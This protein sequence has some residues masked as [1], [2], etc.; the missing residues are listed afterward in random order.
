MLG[1][2]DQAFRSLEDIAGIRHV[3]SAADF[4]DSAVDF[5]EVGD[6]G[7][8]FPSLGI[9]VVSADDSQ[10]QSLQSVSDKGDNILSIEPERY[11]YPLAHHSFDQYL[12][13]YRESVNHL[14]DAFVGEDAEEGRMDGLVSYQDTRQFTWGLQ[15]TQ[16]DTS[17]YT[18]KGIRVAVLDTGFDLRHIDFRNRKIVSKSFVPGE[19]AQDTQ[20]HGTHCTGTACGPKSPASRVRRYGCACDAD[21]FIGK[22][23]DS[24]GKGT[25]TAILNGLEWAIDNKCHIVSMSLGRL[26]DEESTAYENAGRRALDANSLVIAAAGNNANRTVGRFG[27]VEQPANSLSIMA[28]GAVDNQLRIA[29]FSARSSARTGIGGKVDLVAPGVNV[30]SSIP[31]DRHASYSGTSMATPH[32]AGIAALW[33]QATGRLGMALWTTLIQNTRPISGDT[34]DIGSG[35]VQAPQ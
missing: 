12:R 17:R 9:A 25:D 10:L 30:F 34:R 15:S 28:V 3:C 13:G 26:S 8:Y 5:G 21:I 35:L 29:N 16:V 4:K 7:L 6:R 33:A 27:F 18:G 31:S 1:K 19:T 22:V 32:V 14:Y 23:L 2:P 11:V 24:G 20:G